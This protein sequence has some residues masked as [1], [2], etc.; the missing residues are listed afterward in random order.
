MTELEHGY[1]HHLAGEACPPPDQVSGRTLDMA[2]RAAARFAAELHPVDAAEPDV[3]ELFG[4][5]AWRKAAAIEQLF[6]EANAAAPKRSKASDGTIGNAAHAKLGKGSDHNAWLIYRGA[7]IV[8]AGDVTNDPALNLPAVWDRARQAAYDRRLPQ[9]LDGGYL[10]LN[11]AISAEDFSG[12]RRYTG[13]NPHVTHGHVSV[14]LN[15]AQ[16]DLSAPWGIFAPAAAPP[17][18]RPAP[19]AGF[20]GPDL[21]GTGLGLRGE[22]GANGPRVAA[23]QAFLAS[24]YPAYRHTCGELAAD[25]WWGPVTSRWNREFAHRSGITSS[26]GLNIGPKL[27]A[28]YARAGLFRNLSAARARAAGHV[29]R[30]ARR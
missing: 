2:H 23:W 3:E 26:D 17:P 11:G 12:W 15:P 22:Q 9:L 25:G 6:A 8:R 4:A 5:T 29:P 1:P 28:T 16:F 14:S 18:P 21:T 10:I 13:S 19:P 7:G 20:T 30:G 27:A 24:R